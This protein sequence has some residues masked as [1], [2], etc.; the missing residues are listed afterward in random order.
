MA[1]LGIGLGMAMQQYTLVVQNDA[2]QA[3]LG[4]RDRRRRSSSATWARP[5]AS[6]SSARS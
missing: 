2:A 6:R 1:V 5:S 3:D 4:R